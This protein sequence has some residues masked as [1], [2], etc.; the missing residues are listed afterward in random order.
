MKS[1]KHSALVFIFFS[2][3]FSAILISFCLIQDIFF[4]CDEAS[5]ASAPT[6]ITVVLDAGHGGEDGGANRDGILEKDLNLDITL[7]IG[8]YLK[9]NGIHVVYTRTEDTLLYDKNANY[10]GRKKIL[11]LAARLKIS[12]QTENG[13]FISIHMNAFP[14]EKYSGLQVYYS[15]NQENSKILAQLIQN[16]AKSLIDINNNRKIKTATSAIYLL[17]RAEN[18][19]VLVECGFLSNTNDL[20]NLSSKEYRQRLALVLAESIMQ[21]LLDETVSK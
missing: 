13:I 8:S 11:D 17:D 12:N 7:A 20:A 19:A 10:K 1:G 14:S 21:Y 15:K 5:L 2:I 3:L 6:E 4:K 16:N 18:P 9:Q